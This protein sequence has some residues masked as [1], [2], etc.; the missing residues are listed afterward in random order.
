MQTIREFVT[1]DR[2]LPPGSAVGSHD[3]E[4]EYRAYAR[5]LGHEVTEPPSATT[6]RTNIMSVAEYEELRAM[7]E[8]AP[9]PEDDEAE[10]DRQYRRFRQFMGTVS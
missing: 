10:F 8:F 3:E 1:D 4:R 5:L 9:K 7:A 2:G 6:A